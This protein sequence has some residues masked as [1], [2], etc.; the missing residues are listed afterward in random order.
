[1]SKYKILI[2]DDDISIIKDIM[3]ILIKNP[4]YIILTTGNG[5]SACEIANA[6]T[7]S[8]ILMDW[9]M[10]I[11]DGIEATRLLK[12]SPY[13]ENIPIII[14][15]GIM[16]DSTCLSDALFSG[17]VDFLRKPIDEV[18]LTARVS[19]MLQLSEAYLEIQQQKKELQSQ[20]AVKLLNIQ[21]LNELKLSTLK[22]LAIIKEHS[23]KSNN[24]HINEVLTKMEAQLYSKVHQINWDDFESHFEF[25]HHSF[26]KKIQNEYGN[27]TPNEL[28]LC[29]FIKLAMS[30]KEISMITYTSPDSVNTARKR[31]KKKLGLL[32]HESLQLF[33]QNI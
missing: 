2:V 27:F 5:K 21:Q 20:L 14:T 23:V 18:E 1:M 32:P 11:M 29:A 12:Q 30:N 22:Q 10:P 17:A 26:L 31:L 13:T 3:H 33:I 24:Q 7:L 16:V 15:T 9:Q 28:R 25:V 4:E 19:N 6:E 8:L